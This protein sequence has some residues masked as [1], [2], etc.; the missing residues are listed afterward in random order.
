ME[1]DR[2]RKW[3]GT[4]QR[5]PVEPRRRRE[6]RKRFVMVPAVVRDV[7][8]GAGRLNVPWFDRPLDFEQGTLTLG[9]DDNPDVD[10][11][12]DKIK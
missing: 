1:L 3:S 4:G 10:S 2:G 7:G 9:F 11:N 6:R 12:S 5:V 8:L